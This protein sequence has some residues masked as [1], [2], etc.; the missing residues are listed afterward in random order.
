MLPPLGQSKIR[1]HTTTIQKYKQEV[2]VANYIKKIKLISPLLL[3]D[4]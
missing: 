3:I 4:R 1:I 2:V